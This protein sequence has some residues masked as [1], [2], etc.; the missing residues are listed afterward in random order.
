[1][2]WLLLFSLPS[3]S[4]NI[5]IV[6][7]S[8]IDTGWLKTVDQYYE[9]HACKILKNMLSLLNDYPESKFVWSEAVFLH[10]FLLDFPHA[11][12][13]LKY[14]LSSGR[15]EIVGGGWVMH[16]ESLVDFEAATRQILAGHRFFRN[17]LGVSNITVAWQLDPFGHSSLTPALFEQMGFKHLVMA[18]IHDDYKVTHMQTQLKRS[19]DLEFV[20]RSHG[21]GGSDQGIFTHVLHGHYDYPDF[22][23]PQKDKKCFSRLPIFVNEVQ[24]W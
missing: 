23:D 4:I 1:M 3:S 22:L 18:R 8:H 20:W 11:I 16:D 10:R 14:Y 2:W 7:H 6:P 17:T 5:F 12:P 15:L 19:R 24:Q 21:L 13:R 9:D